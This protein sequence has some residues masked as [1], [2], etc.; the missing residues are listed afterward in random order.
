MLLRFACPKRGQHISE[1]PAQIDIT[2]PC[3]NCNAAVTVPT[4][5][6][7]TVPLQ[8]KFQMEKRYKTTVILIDD[9]A[10]EPAK[11]K[12]LKKW[13]DD[14]TDARNW[15]I[16]ELDAFP[17]KQYFAGIFDHMQKRFVLG[18]RKGQED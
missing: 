17:G 9:Y 13:T 2:A 11:T 14:S 18:R 6:T 4:T 16:R 3:P 1:T 12:R 8:T 7:L 5:S 10:A 15:L